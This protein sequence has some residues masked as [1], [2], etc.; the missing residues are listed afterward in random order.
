MADVST[1]FRKVARIVGIAMDANRD[2]IPNVPDIFYAAR[3]RKV[4]EEG[5]LI[6]Q[7]NLDYMRFSEVK[8]P[9]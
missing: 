2:S 8:L 6:S 4:V 3:L 9:D 1:Q 7:G 5:L